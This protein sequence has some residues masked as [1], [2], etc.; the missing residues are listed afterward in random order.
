MK[1]AV[2]PGIPK[3]T[4]RSELEFPDRYSPPQRSPDEVSVVMKEWKCDVMCSMGFICFVMERIYRR[5][6]RSSQSWEKEP[7]G[8]SWSVGTV[9]SGR[10]WR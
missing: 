1:K 7:S 9:W 6:S 5:D 2:R 4:E 8:L 3:E 10:T